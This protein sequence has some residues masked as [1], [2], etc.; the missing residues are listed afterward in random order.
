MDYKEAIARIKEH[1][2]VHSFSERGAYYITD[3]LATAV[4]A[5]EKQIP[6]KVTEIHCDEYVCPNCGFENLCDQYVVDHIYCPTC[7]QRL[8]GGKND[9]NDC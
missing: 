5:L 2:R 7:G 9:G 3:A 8:D 6:K 4:E 1:N